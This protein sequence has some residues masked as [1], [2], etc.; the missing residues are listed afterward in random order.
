MLGAKGVRVCC[1]SSV[2]KSEAGGFVSKR[3][4]THDKERRKVGPRVGVRGHGG[5][6]SCMFLVREYEAGEFSSKL[7]TT[8]YKEGRK[9]GAGGACGGR[10]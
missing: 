9:V 3:S 6:V 10:G 8:Y 2:C 1:V 7:S 4:T 5:T